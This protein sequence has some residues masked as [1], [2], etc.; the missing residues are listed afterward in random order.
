LSGAEVA[1]WVHVTEN[2]KTN[3]DDEN[4]TSLLFINTEPNQY[5]DGGW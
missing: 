3:N 2:Y 4:R 1:H 5:A